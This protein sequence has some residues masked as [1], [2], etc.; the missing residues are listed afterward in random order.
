MVQITVQ[1][2]ASSYRFEPRFANLLQA[3]LA[4]G[5]ALPYQCRSG[6]CG[7]CRIRLR[8]GQ[9]RYL[10]PPLAWVEEDQILP[11]CARPTSALELVLPETLLQPDVTYLTERNPDNNSR[12]R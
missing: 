5:F 8:R 9:I 2:D 4:E 3:L 11:C 7:R 1:L 10:Q 12:K 6:Y